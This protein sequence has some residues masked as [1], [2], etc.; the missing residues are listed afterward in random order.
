MKS[1]RAPPPPPLIPPRKGEGDD[2]R[3][4]SGAPPSPRGGDRRSRWVGRAKPTN[5]RISPHPQNPLT[6]LADSSGGSRRTARFWAKLCTS[7]RTGCKLLLSWVARTEFA[8]KDV[9]QQAGGWR[10]PPPGPHGLCDGLKS[11]RPHGDLKSRA[12]R[13]LRLYYLKHRGV[14]ASG[15]RPLPPQPEAHDRWTLSVGRTNLLGF[16][17]TENRKAQA[18]NHLSRIIVYDMP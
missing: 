6:Q 3:T 7:P 5:L 16:A 18:P 14:R 4:L 1:D 10:R 15:L 13:R 9:I 11:V 2:C 17:R 12:P 8:T